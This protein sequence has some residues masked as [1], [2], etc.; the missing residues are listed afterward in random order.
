MLVKE[1]FESLLAEMK[2]AFEFDTES[3]HMKADSI[4]VKVAL[5]THL[6]AEERQ[7]IVTLYNEIDKWFE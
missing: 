7:Q 2:E 4:L 5:N 3:G 1:T 6:S